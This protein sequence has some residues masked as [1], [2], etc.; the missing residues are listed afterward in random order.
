MMALDPAPVRLQE[1]QN[2]P[3]GLPQL[4]AAAVVSR[5][6][7]EKLLREPE[8]ALASG[9]LGQAFAL[10]DQEQALIKSIRADSLTD[11]AR[12]VNWALQH[13]FHYQYQN[14]SD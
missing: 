5:Q 13:E 10:T 6:F 9:Y 4:F 8:A 14:A 1:T 3:S 2:Q 11:L 7:R 12:K